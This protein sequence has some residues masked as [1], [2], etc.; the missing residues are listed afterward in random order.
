[1]KSTNEGF[2]G[3]GGGRG[4]GGGGR[5]GRGKSGGRAEVCGHT[6]LTV[7]LVFRFLGYIERSQMLEKGGRVGLM[8]A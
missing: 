1:V 4:R 5:K 8:P 6:V 3:V 2:S 7:V